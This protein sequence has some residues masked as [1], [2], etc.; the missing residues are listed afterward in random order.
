MRK[1][2]RFTIVPALLAAAAF[3][4]TKPAFEVA[5]IRP[6]APLDMPKMMAAIRAGQ[7]PK[8]G[9]RVD[10]G[11]AEYSYMSLR[12]LIGLAYNVKPYQITGPAWLAG[13]W[14]DIVAKLPDGAPKDDAPMMLQSLLEDRF[15]LTVHRSGAEHR[16]LALVVG[17]GGP[18]LKESGTPAPIDENT[19][20]RPGEVTMDS[21]E[22]PSRMTLNKD[23]GGTVDMG[24]RG[25][26]TFRTDPATQTMHLDA[27]MITMPGVADMLTRFSQMMGSSG[28]Q[29]VDMTGLKGHYQL[30]LDFSQSDRANM[31]RS[32]GLDTPGMAGRRRSNRFADG[33]CIRSRRDVAPCGSAGTRSDA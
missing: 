6:A 11:R 31:V 14:F 2:S 7:A 23:R 1:N 16:V 19:P 4:Q 9:P 30:A 17:K 28:L 33:S 32:M 21:A 12:D 5:G 26:V 13:Q 20:L 8:I 25:I 3:A 27:K 24:S 29:F 15:R 10:A 18:K 22:G